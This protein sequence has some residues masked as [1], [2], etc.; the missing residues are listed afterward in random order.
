MGHTCLKYK[1]LFEILLL[2]MGGGGKLVK[3]A[4][5]VNTCVEFGFRSLEC[6]FFSILFKGGFSSYYLFL[7]MFT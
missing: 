2:K 7:I 1:S 6:V 3:S 4:L 5:Y